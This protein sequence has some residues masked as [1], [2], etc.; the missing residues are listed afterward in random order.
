MLP[1]LITIVGI[2]SFG[3]FVND[4]YDLETDA[5]V[6][7][8]NG[9]ANLTHWKRYALF[10]GLVA[11]ALFPWFFLPADRFSAAL[12]LLEFVLLLAYA[13][14]PLRLKERDVWPLFTDAAYAYAVP[15]VLAAHTLFLAMPGPTH[16]AFLAIIVVWQLALGARHYLNHVALDRSNDV[17]TRTRTLATERGNRFVHALIRRIV[18]PIELLAFLAY[19]VVLSGYRPALIFFVLGIFV[20]SSA[21][22]AVLTVGR[23]YPLITYR[24]SR[25]AVDALYQDILPLALLAF[26]VVADWR[27][28]PLLAGHLILFYTAIAGAFSMRWFA[29][30]VARL[31][32]VLTAA[33]TAAV[34]SPRRTAGSASARNQGG[35]VSGHRTVEQDQSTGAAR[36]G[37]PIAIV[38]INKAK[39]TET[40]VRGL[41]ARLNHQVY[42]LHGGEL[43]TFDDD[44]RHF[45]SN[46]ASLQTLAK[47]L[48]TTLRLEENYY[49]KNSIA[50]Y[51]QA[52]RIRL[53]LAEFGPVGIEMLPIA[54]D[55]GLPLIVYFHAYDVFHRQSLQRCAAKYQAM[56]AEAACIIGVSERVLASL[57]ALGAPREKLVHL[58]AFVDLDLFRI[59]DHG[60]VPARFL[61]VGRFA[62]TKSPHLT[63]LAFHRVV[64]VIPDASLTLVGKGGGGELFESCL[65][66]VRSLGLEHCVHFKGILSHQ[67]VA[68]EMQRASVFVQH[69][70]TTP[71][72]G[73]MEGKP[74]AVM[75]AMASGLPV[76]ATRH[77]GI[78]ELIEHEVTGLLVPEYDIDAMAEAMI[79]LAQDGDLAT[80][81]GRAAG[82]AIHSHPL[83]SRHVAILEEIIEAR[84]AG[85]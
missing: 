9:L 77:S 16:D 8:A 14:P 69:S 19:L 68:L 58:P 7:K 84:I 6:G 13:V 66:L 36:R 63:I 17:A 20:A 50:S 45:L 48:E 25:N 59:A 60:A 70:V 28:W 81:I 27:F 73:D 15:S 40:F 5:Q 41:I 52:K 74:V 46:W 83:I 75:E 43:P 57:Q 11:T 71:E 76:V 54:R 1:S 3:H 47:F 78:E 64:R 55:L 34:R 72:N 56:F 23:N 21:L 67:D 82:Q 10:P 49:L 29:H 2:G 61:A 85:N 44:N 4:W 79:R 26:L 51:L 37:L 22:G 53:I 65:I 12:L 30:S 38:N 31:P 24:F 32:A 33:A 39:Y 35:S 18:L 62:E 80:R 42:Y